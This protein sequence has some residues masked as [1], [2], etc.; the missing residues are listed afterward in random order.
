VIADGPND[1]MAQVAER[2]RDRATADFRQLQIPRRYKRHAFQGVGMFRLRGEADLSPGIITIDNAIDHQNGSWL[3]DPLPEFKVTT[4]FPE[5]L[6]GGCILNSVG[7]TPSPQEKSAVLRLVRKCVK[8]RHATPR[9]VAH[10]LIISLRWLSGRHPQIGS[11]LMVVRLSKTGVEHVERSQSV[12]MS[13]GEDFIYVS[14]TGL[15]THFGPHFVFGRSVLT[16]FEGGSLPRRDGGSAQQIVQP[17]P[18]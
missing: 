15:T 11:G 7:V 1:D 12:S 16:G 13:A 9:T 2:I 6:P 3:T 18:A 14:A 17:D 4:Q 10:S 5:K 8:H